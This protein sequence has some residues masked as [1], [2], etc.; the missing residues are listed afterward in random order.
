MKCSHCGKS[1]SDDKPDRA[2]EL[3]EIARINAEYAEHNPSV[4]ARMGR[5]PTEFKH[6]TA[7]VAAPLGYHGKARDGGFL[8]PQRN[9]IVEAK[10]DAELA[11][12]WTLQGGFA[13]L[14]YIFNHLHRCV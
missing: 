8:G 11:E 3:E 7:V 14:Q 10:A 6:P 9:T 5:D 2:K 12:E 4:Y 1:I 13:G